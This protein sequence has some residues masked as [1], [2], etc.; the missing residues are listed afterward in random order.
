MVHCIQKTQVWAAIWIT[1]YE[2]S[3]YK[4]QNVILFLEAGENVKDI[5]Y[6]SANLYLIKVFT[7]FYIQC[8]YTC[9]YAQGTEK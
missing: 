8:I 2:K 9:G 7:A 1:V 6:I 3:T 5:Q 4:S